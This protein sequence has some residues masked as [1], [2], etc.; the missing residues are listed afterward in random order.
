MDE[1]RL[2]SEEDDVVETAVL[3]QLLFL[4]PAQLSLE[5]LQRELADDEDGF[6]QRDAVER[7]VRDLAAAGLLHR[8]GA[9]LAPTRAALRFDEL[10]AG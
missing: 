2:P 8:N 4:H 6:D 5:E 7:A 10:L 1:I 9:L 3:Q